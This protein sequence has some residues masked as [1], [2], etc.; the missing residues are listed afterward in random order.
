[1]PWACRKMSPLSIRRR[2]RASAV[3]VAP[4]GQVRG[5]T[6][7]LASAIMSN[8]VWRMNALNFDSEAPAARMDNAKASTLT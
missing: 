2:E 1:M 4:D 6:A 3:G 5:F 7:S 8:T